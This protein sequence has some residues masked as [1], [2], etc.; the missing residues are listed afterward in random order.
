MVGCESRQ[1]E[2]DADIRLKHDSSAW[3]RA[4]TIGEREG[5]LEAFQGLLPQGSVAMTIDGGQCMPLI[6]FGN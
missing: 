6:S 4:T 3:Q 5:L 2:Q 1:R